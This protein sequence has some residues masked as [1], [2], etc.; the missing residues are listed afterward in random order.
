MKKEKKKK[1]KQ[2]KLLKN[3][4]HDVISTGVLWEFLA[5]LEAKD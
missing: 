1:K 5:A 2:E 3:L 4:E